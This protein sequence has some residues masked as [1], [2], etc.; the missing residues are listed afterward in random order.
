MDCIYDVQRALDA[1]AR[2]ERVGKQLRTGACKLSLQKGQGEAIE[3]AWS[4]LIKP[5][6]HHDHKGRARAVWHL[7]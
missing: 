4:G 7:N 6:F 5:A 3:R 2:Q 1:V